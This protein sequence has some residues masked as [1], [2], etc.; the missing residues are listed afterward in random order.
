M[1]R[2]SLVH[3]RIFVFLGFLVAL[4]ESSWAGELNFYRVQVT[5][6]EDFNEAFTRAKLVILSKTGEFV[7]I[8]AAPLVAKKME[9]AG[10]HVELVQRDI[11]QRFNE[12]RRKRD[13]GAYHSHEE[14]LLLL[15]QLERVNPTKVLVRTI[16]ASWETKKGITNRPIMAVK[17]A[18]DVQRANDE[19]PESLYFAGIH[20][21]EVGTTEVLLDWIKYLIQARDS[22]PDV[23]FIMENRQTWVVP[24]L[25][26]DGRE[27]VF[28]SDIWWRK[29]RR[30]LEDGSSI[31]IDLNRN[32][33]F[34]WG[35]IDGLEG[36][37]ADA[38]AG[39][40]RGDHPF[41][42]PESKALRDFVLS[43]RFISAVSLHSYGEYILFPYGFTEA[44][45]P[46]QGTYQRIS[47][48]LRSILGYRVGNVAKMVGYSSNG[49]HDD[50][51]YSE[52]Q[53]K[54]RII[55]LELEIGRTFFPYEEDLP[56]LFGKLKG[57]LVTVALLSGAYP[58]IESVRPGTPEPEG[59]PDPRG[60]EYRISIVNRGL[61]PCRLL[62]V[63]CLGRDGRSLPL[64]SKPIAE[65]RGIKEGSGPSRVV[66]PA[67][68]PPELTSE[69]EL[70]LKLVFEENTPVTRV[71]P[72][73]LP[74]D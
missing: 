6:P 14:T 55:A 27:Y 20:A 60:R 43:R 57:A 42:E 9:Q 33:S 39:T 28:R 17:I 38:T 40:F 41:S 58:D 46:D 24:V 64:A 72:L 1:S 30:V 36:S 35:N 44:P 16:G 70:K 18:D 73:L 8:I 5:K 59:V 3:S 53:G 51:L 19:R 49:R 74:S 2:S 29:N 26:P 13:Y 32:F 65:I 71:I 45:L 10:I 48:E 21:R 66:V 11:I 63:Y 34:K 25:N 56:A 67:R 23:R 22:D 37:S 68:I 69:P 12:A 50:W 61:L 4:W 47:E 15:N 7:D 62:R 52:D 54:K 31:G